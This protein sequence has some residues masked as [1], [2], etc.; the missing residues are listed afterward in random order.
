MR[1][2]EF[3]DALRARLADLPR[4]DVAERLNFYSEMIDDRIEEGLSEEEAV[5][6]IGTV[7]EVAAGI[8]AEIPALKIMVSKL[9]NKKKL[10]STE[11]VLLAVGSP[12]WLSLL[13]AFF[14]V[15]LS[16]YAVLWALLISLWATGAALIGGVIG[17][18]GG[19]VLSAVQ[20]SLPAAQ[21]LLCGAMV[22]AG[23]S[24]FFFFG[25]KLLTKGALYLTK[26]CAQLVKRCFARKEA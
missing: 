5:A 2:Q 8:K 6:A 4:E 18:I 23:L 3:L 7:D 1:K 12:L 24:I 14:A 19:A 15:V 9:K 17:G 16:L 13:V 22:S 21:V 25:C 11:I 20:G 10:S 26:K